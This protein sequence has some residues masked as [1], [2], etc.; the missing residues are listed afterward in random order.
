MSRRV[1][2]TAVVVLTLL[3]AGCSGDDPAPTD[4]PTPTTTATATASP[5]PTAPPTATPVRS[6]A[7][8]ACY[9]LT[10]RQAVSPTSSTPS[11]SCRSVHTSQTYQVGRID[12]VVDGHLLAVDSAR[13][14]DDVAERCPA[15]LGKAVGG[16]VEAQR[17]SML[18]SVWFTPSLAQSGKGA[19]WYRCDVVALA[20]AKDLIDVR[21]SLA[22]VLDTERGR[23]R[24]GMCGSARPD[25]ARFERVP[26]SARHTWRAFSVIGLAGRRY[27]GAKAVTAA[28]SAC[29]EAAVDVVDDP[30]DYQWAYE[31]PDADE[32]AAGQTYVRC[33]APD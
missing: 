18:R 8:N 24:Y 15:A 2:A 32:W 13:V 12:N 33:W 25:S 6:P 9:R 20:G 27:P 4:V 3:L 23:D 1:A 5:T 19:A 11:T 31:G 26:C 22:G 17:L 16:T 21:G 29:E 10:Y 28:G 7:K 30:L 14:Q